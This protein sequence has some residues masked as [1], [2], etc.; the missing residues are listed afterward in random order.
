[1]K[2]QTKMNTQLRNIKKGNFFKRLTKGQPN[3]RVY[4]KDYYDRELKAFWCY[5]YDDVNDGRF[6]KATTI[7]NVGFTF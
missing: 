6:I 1:M 4:V 7:V 2:G 3:N 5:P